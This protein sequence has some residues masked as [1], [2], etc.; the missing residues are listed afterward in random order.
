MEKIEYVDVE[1]KLAY[2]SRKGGELAEMY[3]QHDLLY[4]WLE[5][6]KETQMLNGSNGSILVPREQLQQTYAWQHDEINRIKREIDERIKQW[7]SATF[8]PY[9]EDNKH[10]G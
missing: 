10:V 8:Q 4:K 3:R 9:L 6:N 7:A 1:S 5:S 2:M